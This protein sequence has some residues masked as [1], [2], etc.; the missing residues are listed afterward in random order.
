MLSCGGCSSVEHVGWTGNGTVVWSRNAAS[1]TGA[2]VPTWGFSSSPLMV[3]DIVI[4]A[5]GG[6]LVAYDVVTGN[7]RWFAKIGGGSYSSPHLMTIGGV[8]QVLMLSGVGA[9]SI[10]PADGKA[11]LA[12]SVAGVSHRAA[13]SDRGRRCSDCRRR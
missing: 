9:T 10:A 4:V 3:G 5:A 12:T 2:E 7:P 13:R 6:R 8:A 11:A 1:D